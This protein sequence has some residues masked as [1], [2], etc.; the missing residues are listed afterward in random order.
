MTD[1]PA[2]QTPASDAVDDIHPVARY[3][4]WI[5][6]KWVREGA[7]WLL[8]AASIALALLDYFH[9]RHEYVDWADMFGFYSLMGFG[10]FAFAVQ[11]GRLL[12]KLIQRPEDFYDGAAGDE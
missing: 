5:D 12:R 6:A 11:A 3:L 2:S 1:K 7:M 9:L 8:G 4:L 10:C